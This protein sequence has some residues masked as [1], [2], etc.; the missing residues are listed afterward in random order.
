MP[1]GAQPPRALAPLDA[2]NQVFGEAYQSSREHASRDVP[3]LVLLPAEVVVRC[4][5]RRSAFPVFCG[6]FCAAKNVA[7][8]VVALF[9]LTLKEAPLS[10]ES[11]SR[12]KALRAHALSALEGLDDPALEKARPGLTH[13]LELAIAFAGT[14][15]QKHVATDEERAAFARRAGPQILSITELATCAQIAELHEVVETALGTLSKDE[16]A[17]LQIV[18]VGDHQARSRSLGMQ[19]FQRR[20]DERPGDDERVTY[21]ENITDEK[22]ALALVGTRQLDRAIAGAFFGDEKRLQRDVLGAAPNAG[23]ENMTRPP[24]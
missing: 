17:R 9:A 5:G 3:I 2:A 18:V 13:L 10:A 11:L 19:Y 16:R 6:S 22:E 1:D 21:G 15:V 8:I 4:G 12:A 24:L 14:V 20:L 7:H 23:L